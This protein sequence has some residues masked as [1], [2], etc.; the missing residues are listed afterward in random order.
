MHNNVSLNG[1][2]PKAGDIIGFSGDHWQSLVINL[3]TYGI[4]WWSLSHIGIIGEYKG[5]PLLFESTTLDDTPCVVRG[6]GFQGTQAQHLESR[7]ASYRGKVWHYP[8]YRSLFDHEKSRLNSFLLDTIGIPYD[9]IGA[10]R[11]GGIG[12]SWLESQLREAD[13][14]SLFCSEW[15]CAA[16]TAIG[17]FKTTNVSRYSPNKFVRAERR[18][19]LLLSPRRL[20]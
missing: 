14:S 11:A 19:E 12:Y 1:Q 20:K 3:V 9:Q 8:L 10:F 7:L 16:H 2:L 15:C 6:R 17:L 5:Q 18:Q 4:P 13:L